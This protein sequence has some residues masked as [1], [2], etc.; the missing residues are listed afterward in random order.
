MVLKKFSVCEHDNKKQALG[1]AYAHKDCGYMKVDKDQTILWDGNPYHYTHL[2][3]FVI[4]TTG[5]GAGI[6]MSDKRQIQSF[7]KL[8]DEMFNDWTCA[9]KDQHKIF[10]EESMK[11]STYAW[12][13]TIPKGYKLLRVGAVIKEG[14]Q[15]YDTN[16]HFWGIAS[17]YHI[18]KKVK[19]GNGIS[20]IRE[21]QKPKRYKGENEPLIIRKT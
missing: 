19:K 15:E 7:R 9:F 2:Y 1:Y 5:K 16:S 8:F 10:K 17:W 11:L 18:G 6:D 13:T 21:G 14:D 4:V 3:N 12:Q 20:F